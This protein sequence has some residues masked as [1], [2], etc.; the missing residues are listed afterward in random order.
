MTA[1]SR[2]MRLFVAI[3]ALTAMGL[4][5]SNDIISNYFK[6]TYQATALQRG[7]LELPREIPGILCL[8]VIS[9]LSFL[10]DIRISILSQVLSLTGMVILGMVT[11]SY[12]VMMIFIFINSLGMHLFFI[13]QDSIGLALTQKGET[14]RRMGQFR[15][16]FTGFQM[17]AAIFVFAG[18]RFGF[19]SFETRQKIPFLIAG[20]LF[21]GVMMLLVRLERLVHVKG[22]VHLKSRMAIKKEY[23]Y[24]YTL[25]IMFGVQKQIM[26]VY[27][28]WLL[29][30]LLGK[31]ADTIAMLAMTG[32][33]IGIFFI[34]ALGRWM[35]RFGIKAMLYADALSFIGVYLIYGI[36]AAGYSSGWLPRTGWAIVPAFGIIIL[37]RM[38]TQM[39]LVRTVYLKAIA[40]SPSDITPGLSVGISLDHI[41]TIVCAPLAG[42]VWG[43]MGPQYIFFLAAL[44]SLVNLY[45]AVKVRLPADQG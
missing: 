17:L 39:G 32:G 13:L 6:D 42:M 3:L 31:K 41:M 14:G 22:S 21:I 1:M 20:A 37:D 9:L 15:G 18:F 38:S 10:N 34:P 25:A 24:Y 33:F 44:L 45:I 16:I 36:L 35:D 27:G 30:D 29:I 11:P 4:G 43:T 26:L 2:E 19:L 12:L 40:K 5:F 7:F 23:M 28:P 8:F